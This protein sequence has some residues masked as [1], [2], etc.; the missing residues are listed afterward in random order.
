MGGMFCGFI[1]YDLSYL[2]FVLH[3]LFDYQKILACSSNCHDIPVPT[4]TDVYFQVQQ[5]SVYPNAGYPDQF[6]PQ[7]KFVEDSIELNCLEITG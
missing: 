3:G 6:G 1:P 5:N 7:G 2:L 4:T